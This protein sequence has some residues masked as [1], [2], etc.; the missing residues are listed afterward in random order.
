[1]SCAPKILPS[2]CTGGGRSHQAKVV[3]YVNAA[4]ERSAIEEAV[5]EFKISEALRNRT[6]AKQ[7]TQ[8]GL[9]IDGVLVA[10]KSAPVAAIRC[11][12]VRPPQ[13][14][15]HAKKSHR[16]KS[17]S[18]PCGLPEPNREIRVLTTPIVAIVAGVCGCVMS[19]PKEFHEFAEECLRWAEQTDDKEERQLLIDLSKQWT[20]AA[21][22]YERSI[23]L[24]GRQS[25]ARFGA[26]G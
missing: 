13:L 4:G 5:K 20:Q 1:M 6:L 22:A 16:Q 26:E 21:L 14:A 11:A 24:V 10:V 8:A 17:R 23:A 3:G 15:V 25:V 9:A 2:S 19:S 12:T 7:W 18:G